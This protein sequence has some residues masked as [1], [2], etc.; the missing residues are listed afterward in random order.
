[1]GSVLPR[2]KVWKPNPR[3]TI[4]FPHSHHCWPCPG[5]SLL[6]QVRKS[7]RT[8]YVMPINRP[9][10][11]IQ[12]IVVLLV[13]G[14]TS[15]VLSIQPLPTSATENQTSPLPLLPPFLFSS[16]LRTSVNPHSEEAAA[17][18]LRSELS[19]QPCFLFPDIGCPPAHRHHGPAKVS[20]SRLAP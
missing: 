10:M 19:R 4:S 17:L 15:T 14:P 9:Q 20:I 11:A 12:K 8:T 5:E 3:H 6:I 1:M 13:S 2:R 7:H 16:F 18:Y